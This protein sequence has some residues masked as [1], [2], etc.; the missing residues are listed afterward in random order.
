LA[1]AIHEW[2]RRISAKASA[3]AW[4]HLKSRLVPWAEGGLLAA[5]LETSRTQHATSRATPAAENG[6]STRRFC[7]SGQPLWA[8]VPL[9]SHPEGIARVELEREDRKALGWFELEIEFD[10]AAADTPSP[11]VNVGSAAP[12]SLHF[13]EWNARE[14]LPLDLE[15]TGA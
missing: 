15:G 2:D 8:R 4:P 11:A 7:Y 13:G 6:A 5:C 1:S 10:E 14:Q 12:A 9:R 3:S